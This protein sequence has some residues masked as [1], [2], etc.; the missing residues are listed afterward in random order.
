MTCFKKINIGKKIFDQINEIYPKFYEI[1]YDMGGNKN[2]DLIIINKT[3]YEEL[4]KK[5][6]DFPKIYNIIEKIKEENIIK[7]KQKKNSYMKEYM[8]KYYKNNE[9]YRN[10]QLKIKSV[11]YI[12]KKIIIEKEKIYSTEQQEKI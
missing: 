11:N 8:K 3:I 10:N 9:E 2:R 12:I 7:K 6:I 5:Y 4:C 1:Y